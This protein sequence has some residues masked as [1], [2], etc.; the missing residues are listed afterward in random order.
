MPIVCCK[1]DDK[2]SEVAD[3]QMMNLRL[4]FLHEEC[5]A[6]LVRRTL[7]SARPAKGHLIVRLTILKTAIN[8]SSFHC[9]FPMRSENP[10]T[11]IIF[12]TVNSQPLSKMRIDQ[13]LFF[14]LTMISFP[15]ELC[16]VSLSGSHFLPNSERYAQSTT[17][18]R[19]SVLRRICEWRWTST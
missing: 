2:S 4:E 19:F 12:Q 18:Q 16:N 7:F 6:R 5:A 3:L 8:A 14:Q 15:S 11:S 13:S 17:L 1:R 10:P 9:G